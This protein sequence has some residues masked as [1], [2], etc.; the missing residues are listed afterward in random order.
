[1]LEPWPRGLP[2]ANDIPNRS[3]DTV[4]PEDGW[5]P[6]SLT[7]TTPS[8]GGNVGEELIIRMWG[9]GQQVNFD[10]VALEYLADAPGS[11]ADGLELWLMADTGVFANDDCTG[12]PSGSVGCWEDQSGN[13]NH[14]TQTVPLAQPGTG[15]NQLNG[16]NVLD[17]DG[18]SDYL[19]NATALDKSGVDGDITVFAA[20]SPGSTANQRIVSKGYDGSQ[21]QWELGI[22]PNVA[23]FNRYD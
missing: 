5:S 20:V 18:V 11:V 4:P 23:S 14:V 22:R 9:S 17:F 2:K 12:T 15:N 13:G 21:T 7:Y 16:L 6:W 1:M 8:S 10:M 19:S 3:L